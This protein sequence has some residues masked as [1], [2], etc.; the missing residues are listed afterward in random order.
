MRC[1]IVVGYAGNKL[2]GAYGITLVTPQFT[3]VGNTKTLKIG[4]IKCS[5]DMV[6]L[7]HLNT[8]QEDG[9]LGDTYDWSAHWSGVTGWVGASGMVETDIPFT[10]GM[11]FWIQCD[12]DEGMGDIMSCGQ[13]STDDVLTELNGAYGITIVGN[14]SP[15]QVNL[16]DVFCPEELVELV[17]LNTLQEDGQL[18]DTYDWSAHWSGVTG[19]VGASGMVETELMLDPGQAFWIQC[20]VDEGNGSITFPGVELK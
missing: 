6:E 10:P 15:V 9:Q 14:A 16:A 3:Q 17:H 2:N 18:G 20:D 12:V 1:V 4:D 11:G 13:V 19:W 5:D 8:L 7:V